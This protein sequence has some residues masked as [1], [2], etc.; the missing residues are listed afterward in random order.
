MKPT[1]KEISVTKEY[2]PHQQRVI[3][4]QEDLSS[5]IFKLECFTDTEI[6]SR[7]SHV[8]R[9]MLINQLDVMKAYELILRTRIARF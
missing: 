5:R 8:D 1:N 6:F 4:E 7:L 2:L 9:N 3:E